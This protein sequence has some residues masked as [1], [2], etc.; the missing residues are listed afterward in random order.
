MEERLSGVN[1]EFSLAW[2]LQPVP[3]ET[4]L[5]EIW[6]AT[7]YHVKRSCAGYFDGLLHGRSA[8]DG[9]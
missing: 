1:V 5:H 4:F 8:V 6:G 2:L 7:H 9:L 3:V